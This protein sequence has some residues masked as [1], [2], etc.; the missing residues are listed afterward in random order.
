MRNFLSPFLN[1]P[2]DVKRALFLIN[3]HPLPAEFLSRRD[4]FRRMLSLPSQ[5]EYHN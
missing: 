5:N 4:T 3:F 2:K 1:Q